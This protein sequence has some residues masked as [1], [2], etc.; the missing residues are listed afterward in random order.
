VPVLAAAPVKPADLG[1]PEAG[2]EVV[3]GVDVRALE[4]GVLGLKP[5]RLEEDVQLDPD[6]LLR[7][8][9]AGVPAEGPRLG[10]DQGAVVGGEVDDFVGEGR[11]LSE[12]NS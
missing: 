11:A 10:I 5:G 6:V 9:C 8:V 2:L 3:E 7:S 12:K 4:A 1:V